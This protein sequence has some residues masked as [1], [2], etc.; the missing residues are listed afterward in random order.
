MTK[1]AK[2]LYY[3]FLILGSVSFFLWSVPI[4]LGYDP[5]VSIVNLLIS[6]LVC[7]F[8]LL[9]FRWNVMRVREKL[10]GIWTGFFEKERIIRKR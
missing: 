7:G 9:H 5:I 6:L 3:I 1:L 4:S 10:D 2:G 8:M